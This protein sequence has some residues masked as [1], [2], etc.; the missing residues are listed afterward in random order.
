MSEGFNLPGLPFEKLEKVVQAYGRNDKAKSKEEIA[1]ATGF[2]APAISKSNSFLVDM[3]LISAGH[4]KAPTD[5][6]RSL[7]REIQ[8]SNDDAIS[9]I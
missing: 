5:R 8:F 3:G 6:G 1:T 2:G 4:S 9:K 7:S